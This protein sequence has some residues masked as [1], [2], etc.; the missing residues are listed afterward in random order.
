MDQNSAS[1]VACVNF[2]V[3]LALVISQNVFFSRYLGISI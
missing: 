2:W 3:N 1:I